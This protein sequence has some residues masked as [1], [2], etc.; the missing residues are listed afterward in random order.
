MAV[1]QF[2]NSN[3]SYKPEQ[4]LLDDLVTESIQIHGVNTFYIKRTDGP[5]DH[6]L[7]EDDLPTY[8]DA[9]SVEMYVKSVDGFSGEG[10]FLSKFGLTV[11]DSVTLVIGKRTFE[12]EI[13]GADRSR[14]RPKE[15]DLV[16]LPFCKKLFE[17]MFVE[18]EA[19]F[20]QAGSIQAYEL[21]CE[22]FE[23]TN[24]EMPAIDNM[25]E[26]LP[27]EFD[28]NG[29]D[30][31][32]DL[33]DIDPIANNIDFSEVTEQIIDFSESDPFSEEITWV[34]KNGDN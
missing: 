16:W 24:D 3:Y 34:K 28:T 25:W 22:L 30:A 8:D 23:F 33:K 13:Y 5:I 7:N 4:D 32:D 1:S 26:G 20:Y 2:F 14:N 9:Y 6:I 27:T 10:D 29:I 31:L 17:I 19:V 15:G 11:R 21:R 18:A 12:R